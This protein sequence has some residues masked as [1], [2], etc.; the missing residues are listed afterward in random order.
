MMKAPRFLV[1]IDLGTTHTV[2][3]FAEYGATGSSATP[4]VFE[5]EQLVGPGELAKRPLLPSLRYHPA[6]NEIAPQ[7]LALPWNSQALEGEI[8]AVVIGEWARVLGAKT[9]GRVVS[10]AKSWLSHPQ[11]D[12]SAAC[13]PWSTQEGETIPRVT[14]T[15]ASASYLY[16]V[17]QAWNRAF[18]DAPLEHQWVILTVPA[19]FDE[20]ARNLTLQAAE[21]AGI[22]IKWLVE[23]PQAVVYDWYATNGANAAE[24]L[25]DRKMIL[26]CDVG[27]GT[28][29]FSLIRVTSGTSGTEPLVLE[30]IGVGD[31][32]MLGGDNLDLALA[33]QLETELSGASTKLNTAALSQLVLQTRLA[34]EQ[35]LA[36]NAP[37]AF[38]VTLLGGGS[39]LIG[40]ARRAELTRQRVY[41]LALDGF[42]PRV[43]RDERPA[44]QR[45][46]MTT[47]GL[48]Y[49]SDPAITR[50]LAHFLGRHGCT[51]A[52]DYPDTLLLNGGAFNSPLLRER[53]IEV[54]ESWREGPVDSLLNPRPDLSV[55]MGA[56]VYGRSRSGQFLRI[57]GGSAR[58]YF[59]RLEQESAGT[60]QE[61]PGLCLLPK[62][63]EEEK[64]YF[65]TGRRFALRV[66][67]PVKF[68]LVSSTDETQ[69]QSGDVTSLSELNS[70]ALP[71]LIVAL[72]AGEAP[73]VEVELVCHL[74]EL[75]TLHL[76]CQQI[77][78]PNQRWGLAFQV[79]ANN[80]GIPSTEKAPVQLTEDAKSWIASAFSK[81][82]NVS[83]PQVKQLRNQLEKR[84]GKREEWN[85]DLSRALALEMLQMA[86]ARRLSATH[87]RVWLN[88]T[89][90]MLRPGYGA[91]TDAW[92]IDQIWPLFSQ[93]LAHTSESQLWSEWW[94]FWRRLAGGLD[95]DR[96]LQLY[97]SLEAFIS[98]AALRSRKVQSDPAAKSYEDMVRLVAS[99]ERLPVE[100]RSEVA[101]WL[102]NRLEKP[103]ETAISWW[104]LGRLA[105]RNPFH[106]SRHDII[107][108]PKVIP[109]LKQ[110]LREDWR[111]NT[112]AAFAA[113]MISRPSEDRDEDIGAELREVVLGALKNAKAPESWSQ[114]VTE[115]TSLTEEASRQVYGEALPIGL[116]LIQ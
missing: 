7:D 65:L 19:S 86:K 97:R 73:E 101:E 79:R 104:A 98:P 20:N 33:H 106:G 60:G 30:R 53:L 88:L 74:S 41:D 89:G 108:R 1:G 22:P 93:G 63:A 43:S 24:R 91:P 13:L 82:K 59:L 21:R 116:K 56:V 109:W 48:P 103:R 42:L 39:R 84:F 75:G 110:M 111:K 36:A 99:L 51:Q 64:D 17:R 25:R 47:L 12:P 46:A 26:V 38:S 85:L 49:A 44:I 69:L 114:L 115:N 15:L 62:G 18:D 76:D 35:L 37:E 29:D 8:P 87:E 113:V 67:Q 112:S 11:I 57:G 9:L 105:S 83:L 68:H 2:V 72:P 80:H 45:N 71:P 14:P 10:S 77:S 5:I 94:T 31:H 3:A 27:G 78:P 66:G 55:A 96:Q 50:H 34:K 16:H 107:P 28:T 23:E 52:N 32:L 90:H 54:I 70:V 81:D 102:S 95:A 58:S 40:G 6:E 4:H 92:S 100:F 61:T